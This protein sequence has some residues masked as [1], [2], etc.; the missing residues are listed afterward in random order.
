[1]QYGHPR[2]IDGRFVEVSSYHILNNKQV[3][4]KRSISKEAMA[5][6]FRPHADGLHQAA[7]SL[8]FRG[9]PPSHYSA[10]PYQAPPPKGI[11]KAGGKATGH[12]WGPAPSHK[13]AHPSGPLS[14]KAGGKA[15]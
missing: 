6:G 8:L 15:P 11:G 9:P 12:S 2:H 4:V 14:G 10:P 13:G 5:Q 3:E 1:M 7:Q